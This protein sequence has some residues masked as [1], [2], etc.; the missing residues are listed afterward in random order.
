MHAQKANRTNPYLAA[1]RAATTFLFISCLQ[2]VVAALAAARCYTRTGAAI[3]L[4]LWATS[5]GTNAGTG[6]PYQ[7]SHASCTP[8]V[9]STWGRQPSTCLAR[10]L[11]RTID[12]GSTSELEM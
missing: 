4:S 10:L 7:R 6:K 12:D 1:A 2:N 5:T 11:S 9:K 3:R 8:V